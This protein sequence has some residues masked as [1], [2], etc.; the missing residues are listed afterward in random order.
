MP[1]VLILHT[2]GTLG[3]RG[4]P[5]QP[6]A[7]ASELTTTVPELTELANLET[8]IAFNLDSSDVGPEHWSQLADEIYQARSEYDGFVIVHGTDTMAYTASALSYALL[9]FDRPVI[10]TGAQ[11]PLSA[12]RTDARRNLV[13]AVELATRSIDGVGICFDGLLMRGVR[14]T[15]SNVHDY[16]AFDSP[17]EQPLA[18]LGVDVSIDHKPRQPRGSC[19]FR[20]EFDDS[21]LVVHVSPG[22]KPTLLSKLVDDDKSLRGLVLA[23][24]GVGTVPTG[25][26]NVPAMIRRAV[27]G[28]IDVLA[29]TQSAG[30][31]DLSL[32]ENSRALRD[33]GAISGGAMTIEAGVTKL[34]HGLANFS[35]RNNRRAYLLSNV[36]GERGQR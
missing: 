32:Y 28:G 25:G 9:N 13:D 8:R 30:N 31:I 34:M 21:V 24:Y 35:D 18:K 12:H 7:F 23:A 14:T 1:D 11:R 4:E 2:G 10:M 22:M 20:P 33:A 36:V 5:L 27:D 6:D 3:M 19:V 17:G 26:P 16:R 15:K 29:V